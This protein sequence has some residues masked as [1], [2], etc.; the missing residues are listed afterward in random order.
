[1]EEIA[2]SSFVFYSDWYDAISELD[3]E[4][5]LEVYDA[6]MSEV[7][8]NEEKK[9]S[10]LAKMAMRFINPQL[11]RDRCKWLEIRKKRCESGRQG[12]LSKSKQTKQMI[13]NEANANFAKQKKQ[14]L[15]NEAVNVN[16]NVN[17]NVNV[18]NNVVK[19]ENIDT[20][21]S[22]KKFCFVPP[23]I[24]EVDAY[25]KEQGFHFDASAFVNFYESKGWLVGKNKMKDWK[26]A[27]RTWESKRKQDLKKNGL[28]LGMILNDDREEKL[29]NAKGWD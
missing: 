22:K 24:D 13:A 14:N 28:P 12:G 4:I 23:S 17:G 2:R 9:L 15:A 8:K 19:E 7:F 16:V 29:K 18:D 1:M 27:C 11:L 10:P 20:N 6:I 5:R 25:V 21:V 3:A 26:A